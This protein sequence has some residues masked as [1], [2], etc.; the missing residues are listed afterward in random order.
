VAMVDTDDADFEG[1]HVNFR[2][3][4]WTAA[5]FGRTNEW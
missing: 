5:V 1:L 2:I 4:T 3:I